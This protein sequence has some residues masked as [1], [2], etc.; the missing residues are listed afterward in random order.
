MFVN[1]EFN[2]SR[3]G[4]TEVFQDMRDGYL[5]NLLRL[6]CVEADLDEMLLMNSQTMCHDSE[7]AH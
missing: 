6:L 2:A 4:K 5:N 1:Q 7:N 3:R